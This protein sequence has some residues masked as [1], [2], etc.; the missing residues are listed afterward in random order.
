MYLMNVLN[1]II[2]L[3]MFIFPRRSHTQLKSAIQSLWMFEYKYKRK[4]IIRK[5]SDYCPASWKDTLLI[6]NSIIRFNRIIRC[7]IWKYNYNVTFMRFDRSL[8]GV[9]LT[10]FVSSI[11][12]VAVHVYRKRCTFKII[13]LKLRF[14]FVMNVWISDRTFFES[15][16]FFDAWQKI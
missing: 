12:I 3:F 2:L 1:I 8:I 10:C 11:L 16:H 9:D 15:F 4:Q 6:C 14:H 13:Q 7:F 5:G